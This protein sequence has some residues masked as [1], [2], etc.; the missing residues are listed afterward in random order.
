MDSMTSGKWKD[1][2]EIVALAALV[3]SLIVVARVLADPAI[4]GWE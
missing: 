2:A 4:T 3:A 1:I